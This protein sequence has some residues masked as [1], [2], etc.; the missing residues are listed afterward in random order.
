MLEDWQVAMDKDIAT[1]L[2]TGIIFDTGG[3]R[4][5]NT[6]PATHLLAAE[7][8]SH[9]V[10][11]SLINAKVLAERT[12]AGLRLLGDVVSHAAFHAD[13]AVVMGRVSI[14]DAD[15][16]GITDGDLEG[17]VDAML[18]TSGVEVAVLVIE[19]A[20]SQVKLSLR[21]RT[22]VDVAALAKSLD[23]GGGGH[24]RAA[25]VTLHQPLADVLSALPAHL[26][27]AVS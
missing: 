27:A 20:P 4:H 23:A 3:F 12:V 14:A 17:V 13:G 11:P 24:V 6:Q 16:F 25:G 2:Y 18:Y 8:L 5:A 22:V 1:M 10:D 21:S 19:R 9:G 26:V 7:L 15:R